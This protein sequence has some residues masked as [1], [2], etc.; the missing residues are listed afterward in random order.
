MSLIHKLAMEPPILDIDRRRPVWRALSTLYLDTE[1]QPE[2]H[3]E[4]ARILMSSG[5]SAIEL[6]AIL[7]CEVG[8]VVWMNLLCVSGVWDGFDEDQ[9]AAEIVKKRS[10][11]RR[12]IPRYAGFGMVK[13]HW[14]RI[15]DRL[16]RD[17]AS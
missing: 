8:P 2:D 3:A 11:W 4:I 16:L 6:E 13:Q 5:Y 17:K 15:R 9:L 10:G 7:R 14:G 12:W 1:L